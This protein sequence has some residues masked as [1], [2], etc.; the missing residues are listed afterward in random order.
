MN[1][2]AVYPTPD[3]VGTEM[4]FEELRAFNRGWLSKIWTSEKV[5]VP[6]SA[7]APKLD[8]FNDAHTAVK[9]EEVL[10]ELKQ[11]PV[12]SVA[13][14]VEAELLQ[15]VQKPR[16]KMQ[17][18]S[19][20]EEPAS[21]PPTQVPVSEETSTVKIML[22]ENGNVMK[23]GRSRKMKTMEVNETQISKHLQ[24]IMGTC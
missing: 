12:R 18:F 4:C 24:T 13:V 19:G 11:S 5:T 7:A 3:D 9:E 1:L 17:I 6:A 21:K 15:H 16:K 22:D 8:I 23:A 20:P 10:R 2:E 14:H